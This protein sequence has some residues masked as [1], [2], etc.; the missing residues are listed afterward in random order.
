MLDPN[1]IYVYYRTS[2]NNRQE[3]CRQQNLVNGYLQKH[4]PYKHIT[5]VHEVASGM[6]EDDRKKLK[7]VINNLQPDDLFITASLDRVARNTLQLLKTL[8][9]ITN[10]HAHYVIVDSPE[11]NTTTPHG[12]LLIAILSSIAEFEHSLIQ[13]RCRAGIEAAKKKGKVFGPPPRLNS[14][15]ILQIRNAM[16]NRNTNVSSLARSY[17]ISLRQ[18]YKYMKNNGELT[19]TG[20]NIVRRNYPNFNNISLPPIERRTNKHNNSCP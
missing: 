18:I 20:L 2:T 4:H 1:H 10:K 17:N 16:M 5:E 14:E 8:E 3:F 19:Q 15:Q 11:L 9:S 6:K 7:Q 13:A 12:R